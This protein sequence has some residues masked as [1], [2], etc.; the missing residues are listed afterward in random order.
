MKTTEAIILAGGF[1]TR[2]KHIVNDLP[3]PMA[4]INGTPFLSYL[5]K[6]LSDTGIS[7]IVLSTG[8]LHEKIE[9]FYKDS[10]N[11]V[12][13]SYARE[14]D[15]LGTGGAIMFALEKTTS[16]S[17]LV[18]NGDTLFDIDFEYFDTFY[19]SKETSLAVALRIE[20]DVSRYGS[21]SISE[22]GKITAFTEKSQAKGA[23]L[24]N[25]GIY[26]LKK[27]WIK[28]LR[29]QKTFSFEKEILEKLYHENEFYGLPFNDFFIDIGIP[30]DYERAQ[31]ELL[32]FN[33]S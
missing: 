17:I 33:V 30:E 21:V 11:G 6:K 5:M 19:Q 14:T 9:S 4:H 32:A 29:L 28:N 31:Q 27:N 16:D 1:G 22:T 24:I 18:L 20:K 15:P 3:K 10:F 13:I 8:Y 12:K 25:G 7:H 23:G 26:L 2:L